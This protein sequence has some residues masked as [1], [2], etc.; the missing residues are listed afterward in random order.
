M[1]KKDYALTQDITGRREHK[2][3]PATIKVRYST[4]GGFLI[5]YSL[6]LS[7]G[8]IFIETPAPLPIGTPLTLQIEIPGTKEICS[9]GGTVAWTRTE[10]DDNNLSGMGVAFDAL[11]ETVGHHIDNMV[12]GFPGI[13]ILL[14]SG[15]SK[16]SRSKYGGRLRNMLTCRV[17]EVGGAISAI[18]EL[19]KDVDLVV[20]DLDRAGRDGLSL[21]H[22]IQE[23]APALVPVVAI[24]STPEMQHEA[25]QLGAVKILTM[26][27]SPVD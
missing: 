25:Q 22:W 1:N 21:M 2:R 12:A 27:S 23:K 24:A 11:D 7:K 18:D 6:N 3:I 13:H 8:G 9:I 16:T 10:T 15:K 4:A 5:S 19:A 14:V 26:Q 17:T 20:A